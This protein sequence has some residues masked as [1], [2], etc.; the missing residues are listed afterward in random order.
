[1][2]QEGEGKGLDEMIV[3]A[4]L[5]ARKARLS[6]KRCSHCDSPLRVGEPMALTAAGEPLCSR[7]AESFAP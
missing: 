2:F 1:M 7:C 6:A 4:S 5:R 3:E